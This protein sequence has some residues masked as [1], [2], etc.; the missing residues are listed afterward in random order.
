MTVRKLCQQTHI[1]RLL[2]EELG[3][4]VVHETQ[5]CAD[6][7]GHILAGTNDLGQSAEVLATGVSLPLTHRI[8]SNLHAHTQFGKCPGLLLQLSSEWRV[9]CENLLQT[10][11]L[12]VLNVVDSLESSGSQ[13]ANADQANAI[14]LLHMQRR[15]I[16]DLSAEA[17][18]QCKCVA[19][20]DRVF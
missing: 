3:G 4:L 7:D 9:A 5:I 12:C 17:A 13:L 18:R 2:V 15:V 10:M 16:P 14:K 11:L 6:S 19:C 8:S 1:D 20:S